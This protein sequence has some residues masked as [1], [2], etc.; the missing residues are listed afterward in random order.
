M[1]LNVAHQLATKSSDPSAGAD[2]RRP[3][4]QLASGRKSRQQRDNIENA[5]SP[6]LSA[7]SLANLPV[8]KQSTKIRKRLLTET[9]SNA[10]NSERLATK[11]PKVLHDSRASPSSLNN[12]P[13]HRTLSDKSTYLNQGSFHEINVDQK[14]SPSKAQSTLISWRKDSRSKRSGSE[15]D[16]A[17]D[18]DEISNTN[19][20]RSATKIQAPS[21]VSKPKESNDASPTQTTK[22]GPRLGLI[23]VAFG[24]QPSPTKSLPPPYEDDLFGSDTTLTS[25]EDD[26]EDELESDGVGSTIIASPLANPFYVSSTSSASSTSSTSPTPTSSPVKRKGPG[27]PRKNLSLSPVDNSPTS[28]RLQRRKDNVATGTNMSSSSPKLPS[29][30]HIWQQE[31]PVKLPSISE[32]VLPYL[33]A[34]QSLMAR[35]IEGKRQSQ[36]AEDDTDVTDSSDGEVLAPL[37]K[38][39]ETI[40]NAP[41]QSKNAQSHQQGQEPSPSESIVDVPEF[42]SDAT[43]EEPIAVETLLER[44]VASVLSEPALNGTQLHFK[45]KHVF[46]MPTLPA[47]RST[48]RPTPLRRTL[49]SIPS[50][51]TR[52]SIGKQSQTRPVFRNIPRPRLFQTC[53]DIMTQSDPVRHRSNVQSIKVMLQHALERGM[54][55]VC[56]TTKEIEPSTKV[57]THDM[58]SLQMQAWSCVIGNGKG[59]LDTS[60]RKREEHQGV[61]ERRAMVAEAYRSLELSPP[62]EDWDKSSKVIAAGLSFGND[63]S[64]AAADGS[65]E[66]RWSNVMDD[67]LDHLSRRLGCEYCRKTYKNRSGLIYHMERCTMAQLQTSISSDLD[68]ESTASE[69]EDQRQARCPKAS[70]DRKSARN[71]GG[72]SS[73][74]EDEDEEGIIMCICGS[75]EDE[76]AMVQCDKCQ[77]WLHI[78][79]LDLSEDDIPDEY[80]CPTCLGM[81][82]PSTGGK[83]FRHIPRSSKRNTG[84]RR[85]GR[86]PHRSCSEESLTD[87]ED[88]SGQSIAKYSARLRIF[89]GSEFDDMDSMDTDESLES[90]VEVLASPQVVLNHDWEQGSGDPVSDLEYSR[91]YL[92]SL[93]GVSSSQAIFRQSQAPALMLDG[94]SSQELPNDMSNSLLSSDLGVDDESGVVFEVVTGSGLSAIGIDLGSE[95]DMAFHRSQSFDYLPSNDSIFEPEYRGV[96]ETS[97]DPL[98]ISELSID[99]DGLRT[100]VDLPHGADHIGLWVGHDLEGFAEETAERFNPKGLDHYPELLTG[101]VEHWFSDEDAHQNDDFDLN[102]LIDLEA[103]SIP[104]K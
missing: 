29:L 27:R 2:M 90:A 51:T 15:S 11:K 53:L 30:T 18:E 49:S 54:R 26:S 102:G 46:V 1:S 57:P 45:E 72:E 31:D 71:L 59:L 39:A 38:H 42:S 80:F 68:G 7:A 83:S 93:F 47:T 6:V 55:K 58:T 50:V 41:D 3:K 94:S 65:V 32:D 52:R 14:D 25:P 67:A 73:C 99:S 24:T 79:C 8:Q 22:A 28:K 48:S 87:Y 36:P 23:D 60:A 56:E 9:Q 63:L 96:D 35:I 89:E 44:V 69:T 10:F 82:T 17:D 75:K 74:D 84:R 16:D 4:R 5:P 92:N 20:M 86:P 34:P 66:Q 88:D 101:S 77:V 98:L 95:A 97:S 85:P 104:D 103:V 100:P 91:E 78:E 12:S 62:P 61:T 13:L 76:G 33:K 43:E 40:L 19:V 21:P 64:S 70:S 37:A 81:P